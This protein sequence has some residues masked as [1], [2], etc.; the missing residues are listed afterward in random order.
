[1]VANVTL[2]TTLTSFFSI[3]TLLYLL[4]VINN[5][6]VILFSIAKD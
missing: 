4:N 3:T 6:R 5:K 2:L 1:M